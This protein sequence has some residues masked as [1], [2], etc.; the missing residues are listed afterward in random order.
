MPEDK[1]TVRV[2]FDLDL[3]GLQ[4]GFQQAE[5]ILGQG[6]N[7][8]N[9]Q[10]NQGGGAGFPPNPYMGPQPQW[11]PSA[12]IQ[13]PQWDGGWG[14]S[15]Q[16]WQSSGFQPS[17]TSDLWGQFYANKQAMPYA[18]DIAQANLHQLFASAV[19]GGQRNPE[20]ARE[21]QKLADAIRELR[22]GISEHKESGNKNNN[23]IADLLR[24]NLFAQTGMQVANNLY[25]GNLLGAA[26]GIIG[27]GI[28]LLGGP[29]GMVAGSA[30]GSTI[31]SMA[32]GFINSADDVRQFEIA[33]LAIAGKFGDYGN[34]GSLRQFKGDLGYSP[35]ET[36]G[37]IDQLRQGFA[38][39]NS[40]EGERLARAIQE[41]SRALG[42][43]TE[44]VTQSYT[45][46]TSTGG[47]KGP[48]GFRDYMATVVSGAIASG[49]QAQVQQYSELMSSARMQTVM[50]TAAPMSGRA[51][52][53]LNDLASALLGGTTDTAKLFRENPHL[54]GAGLST[55]TSMGGTD[56]PY[57]MQAGLMRI[58]GVA[59]GQID[60][61]FST[62]EQQMNNAGRVL[63]F[64]TA[65]LQQ[66]SGMS[67]AEFNAAAAADPNFVNRL[68]S[69]N[70]PAQRFTGD[71]LLPGMLGREASATDVKAFAQLANITAANG[72]ALPSA[73]SAGGAQVDKLLRQLSGE[74]GFD[75]LKAEQELKAKQME[76]MENFMTLKTDIDVWMK[77]LL[78]WVQE[79][80]DL[81]EVSKDFSGMISWL[82]KDGMELLSLGEKA[83]K[84]TEQ[85]ANDM[86]E[87]AKKNNIAEKLEPLLDFFTMDL[88]KATGDFWS[89]ITTTGPF[90][91]VRE[92]GQRFM[93]W[94]NSPGPTDADVSNW[95]TG[96]NRGQGR[97]IPAGALGGDI[98]SGRS[99][100]IEPV[101][102]DRFN[103]T[104]AGGVLAT[105]TYNTFQFAP[106]DRVTAIA[107]GGGDPMREMVA[108]ITQAHTE[109]M[110]MFKAFAE[111]LGQINARIIAGMALTA[112]GNDFLKSIDINVARDLANGEDS[113][114]FLAQI[115]PNIAKMQGDMSNLVVL[116]QQQVVGINSISL[117][118]GATGSDPKRRVFPIQGG[119]YVGGGGAFG[120]NRSYG[121]HDGEDITGAPGTPVYATMGGV[122]ESI[123]PLDLSVQ[124][125][126]MAIRAVDGTT[127]YYK[128]VTPNVKVGQTIGNAQLIAKVSA[129]DKLSTGP[130]L[131]YGVYR[132]NQALDPK[133][134]LRGAIAPKDYQRTAAVAGSSPEDNLAQY[135]RR[136]SAGESSEGQNTYNPNGGATGDYQFIPSTR[137]SIKAKY[138][139]DAWSADKEEQKAAAIA[140]IKDVS[141]QAYEAIQRG[142]FATA[143]RLLNRTWTSLPG[144][145]EESPL[146]SSQANREKYGPSGRS[147]AST[148]APSPA[149]V[150][151]A[152]PAPAAAPRPLPRTPDAG[153]ARRIP[154]APPH[155]GFGSQIRG[156]AGGGTVYAVHVHQT[157]ANRE[158]ARLAG[159]NAKEGARIGLDQ[160][161]NDW[162][163][164][165]KL[166]DNQPQKIASAY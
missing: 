126:S 70:V 108:A 3:P 152:P 72:G 141:P 74:S 29:G 148:T 104:P 143:D 95:L 154:A 54:G 17:P 102:H 47:D 21:Y 24:L 87:W 46:Y 62:P 132:G 7:R 14:Q 106:G 130:H 124:S 22:D 111:Y 66:M 28:G 162:K 81:K 83:F 109:D 42:L 122:V 26:G 91:G 160:F 58:A 146:W 80:V 30:I 8:I 57:S 39:G 128:H 85:A 27:G 60:R 16:S 135:L 12:P 48:A 52:D 101:P 63:G 41:N 144:G 37:L 68:L 155:P 79:H 65:Q 140:L 51:F 15:P 32:Q 45:L 36:A 67:A 118:G 50:G 38:A 25:H 150:Y 145:H 18:P 125:Y 53:Q 103:D 1:R 116:N 136:I 96:V 2:D 76:V 114:D 59:E 10:G 82:R 44:A 105:A 134:Y 112:K 120:A 137:A 151:N 77:D 93:N 129:Q 34:M 13:G 55:F 110:G 159:Q 119:E 149:R 139:Y 138:G 156:D 113:R 161:K 158:D 78:V 123:T 100:S 35:Q 90:D 117:T 69:N 99:L 121:P 40:T 11:G 43:N 33:N 73:G 23:G 131:H 165:T 147:P 164:Q 157:I 49:M 133:E 75:A 64:G 56:N 89:K 31:G 142:D 71:F 98:R 127:Q 94:L 92:Q 5:Q 84:A 20:E 163:G 19:Q 107:T 61:R 97:R 6:L 9:Q 4:Q 153:D 166:K 88:G 115:A 86:I